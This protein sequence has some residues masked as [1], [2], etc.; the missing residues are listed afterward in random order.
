L[1]IKI[2]THHT[3]TELPR[4][5]HCATLHTTHHAVMTTMLGDAMN[6]RLNRQN[7]TDDT[8]TT[9]VPHTHTHS[10]IRQPEQKSEKI[11]TWC[12]VVAP[13]VMD[14]FATF[15]WA[16]PLTTSMLAHAPMGSLGTTVVIALL[17]FL[18][19][20]AIHP[21]ARRFIARTNVSENSLFRA[22]WLYVCADAVS[23]S[24]GGTGDAM[25]FTVV[26][27]IPLLY[28]RVPASLAACSALYA[29]AFF[30]LT[31]TRYVLIQFETP[32]QQSSTRVLESSTIIGGNL[33]DSGDLLISNLD[34][35]DG[36]SFMYWCVF[37]LG[38]VHHTIWT[39]SHTYTTY[40]TCDTLPQTVMHTAVFR[41][42]VVAV[43]CLLVEETPS[44]TCIGLCST[45]DF[46]QTLFLF[47]TI[48]TF[49]A[50]THC[51]HQHPSNL[52]S[53]LPASVVSS[54]CGI[55]V[56]RIE[57]TFCICII[58]AIV[59]AFEIVFIPEKPKKHR[60]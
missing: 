20:M 2:I 51:Q 47:T 35:D 37:T 55:L 14:A 58:A 45:I 49:T 59:V 21:H 41:A 7:S 32:Q 52:R 18:V 57:Q 56:D 39:A 24:T 54:A 13:L 22:M 11:I 40:T 30:A 43:L 5:H 17:V 29:T 60:L 12:E 44:S 4:S 46:L 8:N 38:A 50:W 33:I 19:N 6:T 48:S 23:R 15:L 3:S 16:T 9:A 1:N 34:S 27:F 36:S 31:A 53:I 26:A 28:N 42:V 25:S 10:T